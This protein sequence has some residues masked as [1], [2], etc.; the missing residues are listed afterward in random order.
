MKW[1]RLAKKSLSEPIIPYSVHKYNSLMLDKKAYIMTYEANGAKW[2]SKLSNKTEYSIYEC[3]EQR[4]KSHLIAKPILAYPI[5][6]CVLR[7]E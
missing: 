4:W 3:I 1:Y 6:W 2:V 7:A 5:P